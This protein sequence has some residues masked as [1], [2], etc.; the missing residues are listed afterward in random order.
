MR[1]PQWRRAAIPAASSQS[2]ITMPPWTKPAEL[3]SVIP[4]H[5]TSSDSEAE[6][7]RGSCSLLQEKEIERPRRAQ[8]TAM[9]RAVLTER[10]R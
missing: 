5:L 7:G 1:T 3:A 4:I 8:L 6:A 2:L 9:P 10:Q